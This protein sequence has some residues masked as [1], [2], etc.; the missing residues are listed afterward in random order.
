MNMKTQKMK[1]NK[2]FGFAV[3]ALMSS[4]ALANTGEQPKITLFDLHGNAKLKGEQCYEL[5]HPDH[6]AGRYCL[7]YKGPNE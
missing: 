7:V 3:I 2:W 6:V 5:F 4:W 1:F